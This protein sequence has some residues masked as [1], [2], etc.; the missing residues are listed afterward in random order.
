MFLAWSQ[1]AQEPNPP[2]VPEQGVSSSRLFTIP[3]TAGAE[4]GKN[5]LIQALVL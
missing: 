5:V 4:Q 3:V 2:S 1:R